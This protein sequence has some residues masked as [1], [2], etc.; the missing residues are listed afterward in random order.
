MKRI[1][2]FACMAVVTSALFNSCGSRLPRAGYFTITQE[3]SLNNYTDESLRRFVQDP[4]NEGASVVVREPIDQGSWPGLQNRVASLVE[5]G[6]MRHKY[7]PRN[8]RLFENAVDKL[9]D[10]SDYPTI[11][12]KTGTD[13]I[14]EINFSID[15]YIVNG[16]S[17]VPGGRVS[18]FTIRIDKRT[19]KHPTYTIYGF[20]VE[21]KVILLADNKIAGVYKYYQTPCTEGCKVK[22]FDINTL[23]YSVP[24]D[25][26]K[27]LISDESARVQSRWERQEKQ[28][29]EFI[30]DIVIPTMF[31]E[32]KGEVPVRIRKPEFPVVANQPQQT[33]QQPQPVRQPPK[34]KQQLQAE[35]AERAKQ[36]RETKKAEAEEQMKRAE[37][38]AAPAQNSYEMAKSVSDLILQSIA[39]Q[40]PQ[41]HVGYKTD[42]ERYKRL[43]SK[44]RE[45]VHKYIISLATDAY[46]FTPM[47]QDYVTFFCQKVNASERPLLLFLN[48]ECIGIGTRSKG[49][50]TAIP[51]DKYEESIITF[52]VWGSTGKEVIRMSSTP[53]NFNY[54]TEYTFAWNRDVLGNAE[55]Q[56]MQGQSSNSYDMVGSVSDLIRRSITKQEP[57]KHIDFTTDLERYLQLKEGA[58]T[59]IEAYIKTLTA[60]ITSSQPIDENEISFFCK[61]AKGRES[62][63]LLFLDGK[64]MGIG[65]CN[66]GLFTRFL[67]DDYTEGL[68]TYSI[69]SSLGELLNSPT[70][71]KFKREYVFEWN[72]GKIKQSN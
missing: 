63:I 22:Y 61:Q 54:K 7:N 11:R 72:Q 71:F 29:G 42:L 35:A 46:K 37:L 56:E 57:K 69:C 27:D 5:S 47:D 39:K 17:A 3:E 9:E 45:D 12:E 32:M 70:N 36:A 62:A 33:M 49:F 2:L 68:H 44:E 65:T 55:K 64:C 13:L 25:L 20:S 28:I 52:S 58:K 60:N 59:E 15:E 66:K 43:N 4:E 34:S 8:R 41:K 23:T 31:A 14:F 6:L 40:E 26:T 16:H 24:A 67:K 10:G 30:N 48:E 18:P 53:V 19:V 38:N 51:K 21:I 1:F 50:F